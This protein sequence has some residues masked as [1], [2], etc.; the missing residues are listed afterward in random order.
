[1][2]YFVVTTPQGSFERGFDGQVGWEKGPQG[3]RNLTGGDL[4]NLRATNSLFSMINLKDQFARPPRVRRD[5]IG[6][7]DVNM[8]DGMTPDGRRW[9]RS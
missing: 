9:S 6:D 7:K 4:I 3:V 1:M 2:F 8:V 5:R